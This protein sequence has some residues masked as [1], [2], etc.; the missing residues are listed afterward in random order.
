MMKHP[1]LTLV[2]GGKRKF[3]NYVTHDVTPVVMTC[4]SLVMMCAS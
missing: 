1:E 3:E 2:V 4:L